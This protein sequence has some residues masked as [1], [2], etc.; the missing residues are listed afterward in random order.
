MKIVV[1]LRRQ[2]LSGDLDFESRVMKTQLKSANRTGARYALF[3]GPEELQ[4]GSFR[5]KDMKEG[6]QRTVSHE[7]AIQIMRGGKS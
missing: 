5:L 7:E 2:G 4:K 3:I 6:S 1:H